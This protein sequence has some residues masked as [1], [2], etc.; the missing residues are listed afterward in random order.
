MPCAFPQTGGDPDT[1]RPVI[2][3]RWEEDLA[4]RDEEDEDEE[5]V[6]PPR[7]TALAVLLGALVGTLVVGWVYVEDHPDVPVAARRAASAAP[8]A[9]RPAPSPPP[10]A[11][12]APQEDD[13]G[14]VAVAGPPG[15]RVFDGA[16]I[17]GVAPIM[18]PTRAGA[19]V[20]R[21]QHVASN[22]SQTFA[23]EV[24]AHETTP[25]IVTFDPH[26]AQAKRR[27]KSGR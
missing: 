4:P 22:T 20:I 17:V 6:G 2:A 27:T 23:V 19:H 16:T 15:A 9:P 5:R 7:G 26:K 10:V 13:T 21:V 25:V 8:S 18:L 24:R 14:F 3:P 1:C 12:V 11:S